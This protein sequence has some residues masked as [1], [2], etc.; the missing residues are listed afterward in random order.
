MKFIFLME[1][2]HFAFSRKGTIEKLKFAFVSIVFF[3]QL[4]RIFAGVPNDNI[5]EASQ[6]GDDIYPLF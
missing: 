5:S 1:L 6:A 4:N 3:K 2:L